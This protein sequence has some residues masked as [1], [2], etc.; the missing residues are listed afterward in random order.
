MKYSWKL[1]RE[2]YDAV[3]AENSTVAISITSI[4]AAGISSSTTTTSNSS[5][6][7]SSGAGSRTHFDFF[8]AAL[9]AIAMTSSY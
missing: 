5:S 6:V 2:D 8:T 3:N 1:F 7:S 4:D 9:M